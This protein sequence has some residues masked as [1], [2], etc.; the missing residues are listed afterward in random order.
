MLHVTLQPIQRCLEP[1][2]G[3]IVAM[4]STPSCAYQETVMINDSNTAAIRVALTRLF[5]EPRAQYTKSARRVDPERNVDL[6][7][8]ATEL[9]DY[10]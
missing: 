5:S 3:Q 7:T 1:E 9:Q 4:E 2:F 10:Y 8:S 6:P